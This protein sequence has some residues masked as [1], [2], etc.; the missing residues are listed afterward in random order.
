MRIRNGNVC[1]LKEIRRKTAER[2]KTYR[3]NVNL[4]KR[5]ALR[6]KDAEREKDCKELTQC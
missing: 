1:S 6:K 4:E 3:S 2:V 5:I